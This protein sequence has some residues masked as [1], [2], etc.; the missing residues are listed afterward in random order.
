MRI[1]VDAQVLLERSAGTTYYAGGLLREVL[2]QD[3]KNHYD[4]FLW[5]L[6]PKKLADVFG[7][8]R[9]FSYCYQRFFPYKVFYKLHKWGID[10]P[11]EFFFGR[12]DLYFFPNFVVYPHRAGKSV[13]VVYDLSFEKVPQFVDR[14]NVE[15]LKK[16]VPASVRKCDHVVAISE[17]T[18]RDVIETY[19]VS[20]EKITVIYPG[21]DPA[22]FNPR[23]AAEVAEVKKKYGI[24]KPYLLYLGTLELRKNIPAI[25]EAYADLKRR[26]EFNLVLAG[27]T[28]WLS[29]EIFG[30]VKKLKLEEDVIFTGYVPAD[31]RP[32][33]LSGAEVFVYPS[34]FEGFGMPVV[35]AQACGTPVIASNSTSLPEAVGEAGILV[36]PDDTA[37]LGSAFEKVLFVPALQKDLAKRGLNHARQFGW[38]RSGRD[39]LKIFNRLNG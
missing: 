4:L 2:K 28:G 18:K 34:F 25:L 14:R 35:E 31:E 39:L 38:E 12:H 33:L 8:E 22:Q 21:V 26:R 13:V 11:L 9:N 20:P 37:A 24:K 3:R 10:V 19:G 5:R 1:G 17:A 6:F 16:F 7:R 36:P 29:E 32:K 30:T 15:F 23:S 27:K